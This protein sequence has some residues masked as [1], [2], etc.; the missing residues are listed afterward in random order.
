MV[1][2]TSLVTYNQIKAK[3][4]LSQ[5]R[6]EVYSAL[7]KY[8][9]CTA[10]E[11]FRDWKVSTTITQQNIHPRLGE[12]RDLGVVTEVKQ[13]KCGVTGR[14][15]I[16]WEITNRLPRKLKKKEKHKC[17]ECNGKGWIEHERCYPLRP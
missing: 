13:R 15:A 16:V 5:R 11:L 2:E 9:P 17:I 3:N 8:G 7:F 14:M 6:M 4:L 1:R 12:L 10:N